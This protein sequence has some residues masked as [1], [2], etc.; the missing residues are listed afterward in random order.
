MEEKVLDNLL[1]STP[2]VVSRKLN[3]DIKTVH[4]Y[5]SR[6]RRKRAEAKAFLAKTNRYKRVLYSKRIGE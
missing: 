3:I 5:L 4:T 2:K 6:V 1:N